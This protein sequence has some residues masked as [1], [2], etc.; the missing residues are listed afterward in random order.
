MAVM[1]RV[2]VEVWGTRVVQGLVPELELP[3]EHTVTV[4][5]YPVSPE[6]EAV[7]GATGPATLAPVKVTNQVNPPLKSATPLRLTATLSTPGRACRADTTSEGV[8]VASRGFVEVPLYPSVKVPPRT[9]PATTVAVVT[10][11]P[12]PAREDVARV[13]RGTFPARER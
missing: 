12:T 5:L 3:G 1:L 11:A 9:F 7:R 4:G 6:L 10:L 2:E 8:E 13:I